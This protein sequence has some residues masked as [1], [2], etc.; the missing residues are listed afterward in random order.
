MEAS[1]EEQMQDLAYYKEIQQEHSVTDMDRVEGYRMD[2]EKYI[3]DEKIKKQAI[4]VVEAIESELE[5]NQA[6]VDAENAKYNAENPNQKEEFYF[7]GGELEEFVEEVRVDSSTGSSNPNLSEDE[8]ILEMPHFEFNDE[9]MQAVEEMEAFNKKY[10]SLENLSSTAENTPLTA[11]LTDNYTVERAKE[12]LYTAK[13]Y[14]NGKMENIDADKFDE[15]WQFFWKTSYNLISMA[16]KPIIK[17][18]SVAYK[19]PAKR[20]YKRRLD[21]DIA[22]SLGKYSEGKN[23]FE[24]TQNEAKYYFFIEALP[25]LTM[26]IP[27]ILFYNSLYTAGFI[28]LAIAL[29]YYT[30]TYLTFDYGGSRLLNKVANYMDSEGIRLKD[31]YY[32][33][34]KVLYRYFNEY[35]S[36]MGVTIDERAKVE[37]VEDE[38]LGTIIYFYVNEDKE[39]TLTSIT[40]NKLTYYKVVPFLD[41]FTNRAK[42][43]EKRK[44]AVMLDQILLRE[45]GKDEDITQLFAA[46]EEYWSYFTELQAI[47]E[48]KEQEELARLEQEEREKVRLKVKETVVAKGINENAVNVILTIHDRKREWKFNVWNVSE[49]AMAGNE[50]Y[51]K[52][53]CIFNQNGNIST[54]NGLKQQLESKFRSQIL[55]KP[56]QDRG[57]FDMYVLFKATIDMEAL[58]VADVKKYNEK[59]EIYIGNSLTGRLSAKW[60]S[61]ANHMVV[62]GKSGAGKSVQILNMLTQLPLLK[63]YDYTTMFITSSSKIGDFV[64]FAKRGALVSSGVE[65]QEQVFEYILNLLTEREEVFYKSGVDNIKNYNEKYPEKAMKQII[66]VADE[67]ENSRGTLDSKLAKRLEGLLVQILNIAR[68]SGALV[69]IG[70]QSILKGDIGTVIDKMFVK[71]SGSNNK[72]VLRSVDPEIADYYAT[73]DRKPQGVFFYASENTPAEQESLFFGDTNYTLIQTPFLKDITPENLPQLHGKEFEDEIFNGTPKVDTEVVVSNLNDLEDVTENSNEEPVE[74]EFYL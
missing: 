51:L 73:L 10:N 60:N 21:F 68:S 18:A 33:N 43:Q 25:K 45:I 62:G 58:K 55:I 2:I 38:E 47:A 23:Q 59:D 19:I 14:L 57:S 49:N 39:S 3:T 8:P 11:P 24:T 37:I 4:A 52:V 6:L 15:N 69:I 32:T 44:S 61:A 54:V 56:R 27:A 41:E 40:D 65:K 67:W 63:S 28:T 70:S 34:M 50:N 36:A 22:G 72:N 12:G 46:K 35:Q 53:R 9:E 16:L 7:L 66:L 29:I 42:L 74:G 17:I 20:H 1:I 5:S 30:M 31:S 64:P 71:F 13:T 48:A 26:L